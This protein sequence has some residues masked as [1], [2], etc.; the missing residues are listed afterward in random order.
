M[1][2]CQRKNK[3]LEIRTKHTKIQ[4]AIEHDGVR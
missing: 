2:D 3:F 4:R 1:S